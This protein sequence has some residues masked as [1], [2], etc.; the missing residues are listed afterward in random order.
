ML[1]NPITPC[2]AGLLHLGLSLLLGV[3]CVSCAG[4]PSQ[5]DVQRK[6]FKLTDDTRITPAVGEQPEQSKRDLRLLVWTGPMRAQ[7]AGTFPLLVMAHGMGGLP[8]KFDALARALVQQGVTI[9]AVQF[10]L[11][12]GNAPAGAP[13][14]AGD[15]KHQP[16]DVS[17]ALTWLLAQVQ[18]PNSPLY[19]RFHPERLAVLGHS[20]GGGTV[21]GLTRYDCCRDKRFVSS[22]LVAPFEKLNPIAFEAPQPA[23]Q[24]PQTLLIHGKA[25]PIVPYAFSQQLYDKIQGPKAFVG[26][27]N[28]DHAEHLE[29]QD[30]P[31]PAPRDATQRLILAFLQHTL[32]GQQDALTNALKQVKQE[33][34]DVQSDPP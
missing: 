8:D 28:T 3:C 16:G 27:Q 4:G 24:G 26:L 14:G 31:A 21:L 33:G 13:R 2:G 12:N 15:L 5:Q 20:Y 30:S 17:F 29:N 34:H 6:E 7:Q 1:S 22:I 9:A 10:P 11:T 18:D 32:L 23:A 19:K 25:D